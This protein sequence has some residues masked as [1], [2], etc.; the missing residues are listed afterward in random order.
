MVEERWEIRGE[1]VQVSTLIN[2]RFWEMAIEIEAPEGN[3]AIVRKQTEVLL[4]LA[5]ME[6]LLSLAQ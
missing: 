6:K 3:K 5:D 4:C 2:S 1:T